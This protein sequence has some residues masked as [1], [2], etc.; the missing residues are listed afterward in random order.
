[1]LFEFEDLVFHLGKLLELVITRFGSPYAAFAEYVAFLEE[2]NVYTG[3]SY[4]LMKGS[5]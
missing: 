3:W 2:R 4:N 1:M 5:I